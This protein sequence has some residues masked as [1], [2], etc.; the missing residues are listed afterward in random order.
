MALVRVV[1]LLCLIVALAG[2][3]P[4]GD[5]LP[6]AESAAGPDVA[7]VFD[8]SRAVRPR[9]GDWVEY[10]VAFPAD[11][12][13]NSLR[14]DPALIPGIEA[15]DSG[16]AGDA[17]DAEVF[18]FHSLAL[19]QPVFEPPAAWR[20]VPVRLEIREVGDDGCNAEVVFAGERR[21]IRLSAADH[22]ARAEFHYD[23]GS[24]ADRRVRI[25]GDEYGVREVRRTGSGYGF[26]RWFSDQVPFGTVRF[27]TG[28]VDVQLVGVGRGS[29]P[30]FPLR[31]SEVI[32]PPLGV[33]Y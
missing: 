15:N 4:A 8:F 24:E 3:V 32:E 9:P 17:A 12:L 28:H 7:D 27:A 23:A 2:R 33:L 21:T 29:P 1:S 25:G 10:H 16:A 20:I 18:D 19:L 26:V 30:D 31:L 14:T 11:P 13:E 5:E 22:G 6:P